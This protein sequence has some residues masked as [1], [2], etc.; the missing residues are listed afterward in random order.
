MLNK[1]TGL[2]ALLASFAVGE[3]LAGNLNTY[4]SGG[5]DVLLCFRK[6]TG[7]LVVDAGSVATLT[8]GTANQRIPIT[9]YTGTQLAVI[10]TNTLNWSAFTWFSDNANNNTLFMTKARQSS[11]LGTQTQPWNTASYDSQDNVILRMKT[12]LTGVN[13]EFTFDPNSTPTAVITEDGAG[14]SFTFGQSYSSAIFG[15][16]KQANWNATFQG[17][18]ENTTSSTFTRSGK[19]ARSDFYQLTSGAASAKWIGYFE[20]ST[21]GAMTYVAYPSSTPVIQSISRVGN[22]TTITYTAG[23]YGTYTLRS[24]TSLNSGTP[25]LSWTAVST[26]TS[27][28]TASHSLTFTDNNAVSFYTITAQ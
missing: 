10:G 16:Q 8:N 1:K 21:N 13:E 11:N 14:G 23:V 12:I 9:T 22:Q 5:G 28:D 3:I 7:D 4:V 2:I 24:N 27:G 19:V 26:L 20:L 15:A 25:L 6:A 18:P 17:V